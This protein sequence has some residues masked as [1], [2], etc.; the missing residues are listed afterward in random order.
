MKKIKIKIFADGANL[1]E[2]LK[3]NTKS[4]IKGFTTNP[5]LMKKSGIKSY[6]NFAKEVLKKVRNKPISFEVISDDI[7]EM[8]KQAYNIASW[9]KNINVKI[10][11]VNSKGKPTVNLI[12]KLLKDGISCNVTAIFK[13]EDIKKILSKNSGKT[14]LILSVFAGRISDTGEDPS[15]LI[16]QSVKLSKKFKNV[17]ILWASTREVLNIFQAEKLGCQIITVPNNILSKLNYLGYSHSKL[18]I[19]TV[20]QFYKDAI[21]SK[22]KI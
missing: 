17:E 18:Q 4:F 1:K 7:L 21:S 2:I 13:L 19:D 6:K 20:K 14:P 12:S 16:K 8:E 10:P 15:N 11:F 3:L 22:F 9:G 5:S